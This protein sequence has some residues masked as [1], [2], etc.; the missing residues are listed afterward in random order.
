MFRD[1]PSGPKP[2]IGG[3]LPAA[4]DTKNEATTQ[5]GDTLARIYQ[6]LAEFT[7]LT[8]C[9]RRRVD[10]RLAAHLTVTG[11]ANG[12]LRV[13]LDQPTLATRWRFQE[14]AARRQ[15][16]QLPILFNL[17]EIR[18]VITGIA[19][20]RT[21]PVRTAPS[22]LPTAPVQALQ[23]LAATESHTNLRQA[24]MALADAAQQAK[25]EV[26]QLRS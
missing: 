5:A 26:A 8:D 1:N 18:L 3:F 25:H 11:W 23:E 4:A 7:V 9:L 15:L 2:A 17:Q 22:R 6:S 14:P 19:A 21:T 16:S 20:Q 13:H 12:V 24:L 10:K